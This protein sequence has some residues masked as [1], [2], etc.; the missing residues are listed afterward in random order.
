MSE[1]QELPSLADQLAH[2]SSLSDDT[3]TI[4]SFRLKCSSGFSEE[5]L[6]VLSNIN[7]LKMETSLEEDS[8][9]VLR[10]LLGLSYL[11]SSDCE[12]IVRNDW[13]HASSSVKCS[14]GSFL[15]KDDANDIL[16]QI[17]EKVE[18]Q[19]KLSSIVQTSIDATN[20]NFD[21][22]SDQ[23]EKFKKLNTNKIISA[24]IQGRAPYL[25]PAPQSCA[26]STSKLSSSTLTAFG[27]VSL[28]PSG[29]QSAGSVPTPSS[30]KYT[31]QIPTQ[32]DNQQL[33]TQRVNP[34]QF[35]TQ[36]SSNR[37]ESLFQDFHDILNSKR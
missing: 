14:V 18:G 34:G 28:K 15:C 8:N 26:P 9:L 2:A 27:S 4:D 17:T 25:S 22:V 20:G 33:L 30:F 7:T 6:V 36:P 5:D 21:K 16:A 11:S 29:T 23:I 10:S 1:S 24:N 35:S 37:S 32:S 3:P 12:A 31:Q 19:S 13:E